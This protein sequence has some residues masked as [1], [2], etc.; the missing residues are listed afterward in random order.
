MGVLYVQ[1]HRMEKTIFEKIIAREIPAEIVYED[2]VVLAFLD[3]KPI[4]VGHTL[5][6]PKQKFINIFDGDSEVLG[7][8]MRVAQRIALAL[9][10]LGACDGVNILM[11]NESPAGQEV[12]HAHLHVIPRLANDGAYLPAKHI[13]YDGVR[14]KELALTLK[15]LL[16]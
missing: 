5:I 1:I 15:Q 9:R 14:A 6:I 16:E 4:N 8:M 10:E 3:I 2:D 12:F 7:H 11:N 13:A